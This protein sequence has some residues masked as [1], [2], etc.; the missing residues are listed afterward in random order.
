VRKSDYAL[1]PSDCAF[2]PATRAANLSRGA[3]TSAGFVNANKHVRIEHGDESFDVSG[4]E[5]REEGVD[6]RALLRT[7]G[8]RNCVCALHAAACAAG[9]LPRGVGRASHNLGDFFEGHI[10]HI[11]QDES[12]ALGGSEAVK[13]HEQ[14]DAD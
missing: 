4:A 2:G 8:P 7:G 12:E 11:V 9:K 13:Y 10:E 5:G 14:S 3:R 6:H 1:A